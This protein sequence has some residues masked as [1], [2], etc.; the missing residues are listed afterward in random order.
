MRRSC[1]GER[2]WGRYSVDNN[3][4]KG[5]VERTVVM[6][7][8]HAGYM[9]KSRLLTFPIRIVTKEFRA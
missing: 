9:E 7:C 4:K 6:K 5:S 3:S 8:K 2:V 1:T